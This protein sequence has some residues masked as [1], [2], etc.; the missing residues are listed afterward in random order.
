MSA[1]GA[2]GKSLHGQAFSEQIARQITLQNGG[3][4]IDESLFSGAPSALI[5]LYRHKKVKIR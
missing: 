2:A 5:K 1:D 4:I 3:Q